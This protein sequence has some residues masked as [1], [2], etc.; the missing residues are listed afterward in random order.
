M[1]KNLESGVGRNGGGPQYYRPSEIQKLMSDAKTGTVPF[2]WNQE[3]FE[4]LTEDNLKNYKNIQRVGYK[5]SDPVAAVYAAWKKDTT[6]GTKR[7]RTT[8]GVWT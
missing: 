2:G 7:F 6:N 8:T 3:Y 4:A 5:D 1:D